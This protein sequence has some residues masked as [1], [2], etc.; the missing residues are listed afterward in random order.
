MW[1]QNYAY[2]ELPDDAETAEEIEF[3]HQVLDLEKGSIILDLCC[4]Q[5]RHSLALA[6]IGYSVIGLDSS[7]SL[8][9]LV[10]KDKLH[11]G[12]SRLWLVEGDMR[13][14]PLRAETCDA[15][16]NL[17]TSFGFFDDADNLRVLETA[18]SV[19]KPGG[20]L[21]I[22]Y[23]NPYMA[24]QLDG[25]RNWWWITDNLLSLAE[26]RYDFSTGRMRDLRTLIDV[27]KSTVEDMT[28]ELR[29]YMLP[30]LEK[31]LEQAGLHILEVYGDVDEREYDGD[32]RRL[33]TISG[34]VR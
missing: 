23:W 11:E 17:F 14:I 29:F 1:D 28:R 21:L 26:A 7:R 34:K 4:G 33:I 30:E 13:N 15:I 18:A 6:N 3:I 12:K 24:A 20:K 31:M 5:G 9:E 25:T 10:E 16:I 19:L 2:S 22:D 8:L 32:S 27:K